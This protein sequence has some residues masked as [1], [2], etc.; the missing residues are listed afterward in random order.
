MTEQQANQPAPKSEFAAEVP[1]LTVDE[2]PQIALR[3]LIDAGVH[4][5]HQTN[6]W[7]PKMSPFIYGARNGIH[8]IDLDQSVRLLKRALEFLANAVARGGQ[9]LFVGTKRQ[10]QEVIIDEA[11]RSSQFHVTG[12]W[13]GGTLTNFRTMKTGI[14]R[15]RALE[16]MGTDGT[17]ATL[18]KKEAL[19]LSRE[20]A[21]LE[22]FVGG[23]KE[24][25]QMPAAMF[26]IDPNHEHIAVS[27]ANRLAIPV[28]ALTDTNCN[29]DQ[30]QYIIPGNDD[31]IRSV[32]LI[33][34]AIAD[35]CIFGQSRRRD[36]MH[37]SHRRDEGGGPQ[38]EF[39]RRE[40]GERGGRG[41]RGGGGGGGGG[42]NQNASEPAAPAAPA[43]GEGE[44]QA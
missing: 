28:V 21:R 41:G 12:R 32:K 30:V 4:F 22:K 8:I 23:I 38:V 24:M 11:I 3:Q 40:R 26:V 19:N 16:T 25:T 33:S 15:L 31:A 44:A 29:P 1:S 9:V 2:V 27:E 39:S 36:F 42:E 13:L 7:N 17:L 5:G 14:E 18:T 34:A 20:Q 6:R 43:A 35:A 10:A 37:V